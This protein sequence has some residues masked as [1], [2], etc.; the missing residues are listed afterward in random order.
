MNNSTR[1]TMA[2]IALM[3][4]ISV[5]AAAG[6]G[7]SKSPTGNT[8]SGT[9]G[10]TTSTTNGSGSMSKSTSQSM[11]KDSLSLTSE[12]KQTAWRDISGIALKVK[13]PSGFSAKVGAA[14][15]SQITTHPVPV[16]TASKV[17]ELKSYNYALLD[18]NK[19]LII[20]PGDKKIAQIIT[21]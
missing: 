20:N 17:P 15:P 4:G 19:L 12:Q 1:L 10:S 7:M 18:N 14:V 11:A 21:K 16:S 3:S 6:N 13:P 9:P 8:T 2:A 5:A